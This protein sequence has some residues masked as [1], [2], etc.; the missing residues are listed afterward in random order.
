MRQPHNATPEPLLRLPNHQEDRQVI[1]PAVVEHI[2]PQTQTRYSV[3]VQN[4]EGQQLFEC[5]QH[6]FGEAMETLHEFIRVS[7]CLAVVQDELGPVIRVKLYE[8]GATHVS[9][10]ELR[11][12]W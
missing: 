10:V 12:A 9:T 8:D 1:A 6:S 7:R 3:T 4:P 11:E 2:L 5:P